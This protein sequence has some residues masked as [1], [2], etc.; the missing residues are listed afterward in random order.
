MATRTSTTPA[1]APRTSVYRTR[2]DFLA[3]LGSAQGLTSGNPEF[4]AGV[5][6]LVHLSW[7]GPKGSVGWHKGTNAD[8]VSVAASLGAKPGTP[9]PEA[10]TSVLAGL[11]KVADTPE[12]KAAVKAIQAA[13]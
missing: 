5:R 12:R 4:K 10:M 6:V 8:V 9:L 3:A 7:K 1:V 11:A 13:I 2:E